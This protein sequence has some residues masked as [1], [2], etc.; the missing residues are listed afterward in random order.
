MMGLYLHK[1]RYNGKYFSILGDSI[2]TLEGWNPAGYSV[3][4]T[5]EKC[6][7]SGIY[8]MGDT[9]WGQVIR[10]LGG[11]LL[12]NN[13]WSGSRITKLPDRKDLFPSACSDERTGGLHTEDAVPDVIII[14]I[15][16]N[17]WASGAKNSRGIYADDICSMEIF[18]NAYAAMLKKIRNNY[19][20]A[21]VWCCTIPSTYMQSN[22]RFQF[23]KV[24]GGNDVEVYNAQ[25]IETANHFCCRV[26]DLYSCG[27]PYDSI[28]GTH[29]SR[30]G[31]QT[32]A[33]LMLKCVFSRRNRTG[34]I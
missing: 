2:S 30:K 18:E 9:W 8:Q 31:M 27:I 22:P 1:R 28:D 21:E 11:K 3:F 19:P 16:I 20:A 7:Q 29:P 13:S 32:L 33:S 4:F 5:G 12:V 34:S 6:R 23:P 15:G 10:K 24:Y 25:I 26:L 14:Y 17:D